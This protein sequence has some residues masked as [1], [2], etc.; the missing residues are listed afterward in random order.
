MNVT[1]IKK[2][3]FHWKKIMMENREYLIE[4]DS[5][6]G[7][8]DLGLT[9]SDGFTA[10]YDSISTN[11]EMDIGKVLFHA[12]KAMSTKVPSTMGTLMASGLMGSGKKLKG[13]TVLSIEEIALLFSGYEE[14]VM[15]LGKAKVGEK[16]FL[17]GFH[18]AVLILNEAAKNKT[19]IN[20]AAKMAVKAA[21]KGYDDTKEMLALHGRAATR[22]EHSKAFKDPG[23]YVACLLFSA[24]E[25]SLSDK[26]G[27]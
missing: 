20:D 24:F 19:D 11:Q 16:T 4:L 21:K 22:G 26:D 18:P 13:K 15:K 2:L 23:A 5:V 6:V 7:D 12:G 10:A 27:T 17:D 14:G 25:K 3:L 8:G 1:S 9:M